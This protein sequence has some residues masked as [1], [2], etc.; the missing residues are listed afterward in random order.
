ML[1]TSFALQ[2]YSLREA[3]KADLPATLREVAAIGYAAVEFA[4]YHGYSA[5]QLRAMLDE[6]GLQCAGTHTPLDSISD[7]NLEATARFNATLGNSFLIVPG[8]GKE[9]QGTRD[10]ALRLAEILTQASHTAAEFGARVGYHNHTWEWAPLPSGDL[11][12]QILATNLPP[13]VV[14]QVD[15]GN[16]QEA[17]ADPVEFLET[18]AKR[19]ATVHLKP[20]SSDF[21][22]YFVG[23]DDSDWRGIFSALDTGRTQ[24]F[25]VEQE[26]YPLDLSPQEC[27]AC[28]LNNL[29]K[30]SA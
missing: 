3:C 18:W 13:E 2:L 19:A 6:N 5:E 17:G 29:R 9:F 27:V 10:G 30:M 7:Q 28:C 26:R 24:H 8:V 14:L 22:R 23:E 16:M 4:G 11:P 21:N 1:P 25:I 15:T 20:F 12:M